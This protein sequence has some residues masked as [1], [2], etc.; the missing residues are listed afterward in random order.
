[1][2]IAIHKE[3]TV[4]LGIRGGFTLCLYGADVTPV[5]RSGRPKDWGGET[6]E[7]ISSEEVLE[8]LRLTIL[9]LKRKKENV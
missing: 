9:E 7:D 4:Y 8:A 2:Q 6:L 1:M 3:E 5:A